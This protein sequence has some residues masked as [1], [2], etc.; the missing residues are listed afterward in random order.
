[1]FHFQTSKTISFKKQGAGSLNK[2]MSAEDS[3]PILPPNNIPSLRGY[4]RFRL[5][6]FGAN[7]DPQSARFLLL[8]TGYWLLASA[9]WL[10]P[11][12]NQ[13]TVAR[14]EPY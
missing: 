9:Y 13:V 14:K 8:A 4:S 11:F 3:C 10:Q 7:R 1:V 12:R 6:L 2:S 5:F